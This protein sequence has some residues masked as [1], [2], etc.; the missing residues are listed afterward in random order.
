MQTHQSV[1]ADDSSTTVGISFLG[2]MQLQGMT[3]EPKGLTRRALANV[4]LAL[5]NSEVCKLP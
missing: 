1:Q 2:F 4:R 5:L 3:P